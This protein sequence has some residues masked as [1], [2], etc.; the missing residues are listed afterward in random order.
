MSGSTLMALV[1]NIEIKWRDSRGRMGKSGA[2]KTSMLTNLLS[3]REALKLAVV[4]N[5]VAS[6][7]VDANIARGRAALNGRE[8]LPRLASRGIG[9]VFETPSEAKRVLEALWL[10]L[11]LAGLT[12]AAVR[13][14]VSH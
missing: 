14:W 3:N 2:G 9:I 11:L 13:R 5:D 1:M 10:Q 6:V 7:N 8:F 12:K 4:V